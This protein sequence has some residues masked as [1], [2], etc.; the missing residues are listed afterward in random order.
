MKLTDGT[1]PAQD[2]QKSG[3]PHLDQLFGGDPSGKVVVL[4]SITT[5]YPHYWTPKDLD[6]PVHSFD[7][8]GAELD[9]DGKVK[10]IPSTDFSKLEESILAGAFATGKSG[11][12]LGMMGLLYGMGSGKMLKHYEGSGGLTVEMEMGIDEWLK[13]KYDLNSKPPR[14]PASGDKPWEAALPQDREIEVKGFRTKLCRA[15]PK[16]RAKAKAARKARHR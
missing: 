2:E 15:N 4:D 8:E 14:H 16:A 1:S 10:A 6:F 12:S 11:K 9:E 5:Q 7:I 3:W 13:K